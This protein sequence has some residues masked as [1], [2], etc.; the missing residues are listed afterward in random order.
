MTPE[1]INMDTPRVL[2][3]DDDP[4]LIKAV[5]LRLRAAGLEVYSACDGFT[6]VML[7]EAQP[8]DLIILD[9]NMP[10]GNGWT[11]H[12]R[13]S[14]SSPT[15]QIP[16]VY[17]TGDRSTTTRDKAMHIGAY[18]VLHKPFEPAELVHTVY[19]ILKSRGHAAELRKAQ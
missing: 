14:N 16:I 5:S 6:A 3:A 17:L 1:M 12:Q 2:I 10:V 9:V 7:A 18:K 4:A 19:Q 11:V 15:A 8:P 13:L